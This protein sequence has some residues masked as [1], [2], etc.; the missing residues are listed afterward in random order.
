MADH[1]AAVHE[2]RRSFRRL[3]KDAPVRLGKPTSNLFRFRESTNTHRLDV[4]AFSSVLSV[5]PVSRT[6]E[7][8]GMTTYEDLVAATLPH[9]LMPLVVPQLRT[10]TLGGAVTG[11]GIESS[12]FRNGLPHESVQ[13]IEILTGAGDVVVARPD[14]EHRELFRG[15]PNSYGTLG[16]SLRIRIEL[17]PVR[18]YVHLRHLPFT[19]APA[20]MSALERVC[21]QG[22]HAGQRVDF[23]DGVAFGP[24]EL[25]LTLATFVDRAPWTSDYTGSDI[26][27][28]SIP[29]YAGSGPGDY[30]TTEDYLW[31]W[32]TDWFWC[33]R[34]FGVQ[35]PVV[36]RLWPRRWKRSDVYRKLVALD[37][38]TDFSRLLAHYRGKPQSEPVIQDIEVG[39]DRGAEFLE[40]F[41][42]QIGM[43]P[44]WMCPLRLR[45]DAKDGVRTGADAEAGA[46]AAPRDSGVAGAAEAGPRWPLYPLDEDRLYVNFGFWGLVPSLPGLAHDHHNRLIEREVSR[47]GGHKSLYSDAFYDEDEFWELYNGVGYRDLKTAY[48]PDGRLLDLY[49]KCVGNR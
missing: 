47:L 14:N 12:S 43:R 5:D 21:A 34:A 27:Y 20:A 30:L 42:A 22:E 24:N 44:I 45:P 49:A 17:E 38:R 19:D 37:R 11:L 26:Y 36:R 48:D 40:F 13:E 32:D 2:L 10:I 7:V 46:D 35:H 6:A 31:R 18:P 15:F 29:R 23:V 3:P 39:V 41:H 16:Y 8:G 9:G 33:S 1:I 4:S 28:T 25:Y